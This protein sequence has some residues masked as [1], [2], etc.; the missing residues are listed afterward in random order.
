MRNKKVSASLENYLEVI[1]NLTEEFTVARSKDIA[2]GLA[3]SKASVTGALKLLKKKGLV[4]YEPYGYI[5]L[6]PSGAKIAAEVDRKHRV[7]ESFFV[8]ILD[9]DAE[10]ARDAAC[11]AEHVLG[12]DVVSKLTHFVEYMNQ[13][14]GSVVDDF[15]CYCNSSRKVK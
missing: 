10:T 15:K 4:N 13:Q 11:R 7:I 5:T 6:T 14:G 3:V 8:E 2:E 9:V 1:F 12:T